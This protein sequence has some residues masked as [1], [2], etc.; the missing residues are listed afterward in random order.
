MY[1]TGLA[2]SEL[3]EDIVQNALKWFDDAITK[4]G[5]VKDNAYS[6]LELKVGVSSLPYLSV[7]C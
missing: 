4:E 7:D 2:V 3:T 6:V 1:W 5:T